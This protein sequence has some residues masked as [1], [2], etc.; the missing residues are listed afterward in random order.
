[1][2]LKMSLKLPV[3]EMLT[4][5]LESRQMLAI[6]LMDSGREM[7]ESV[8]KSDLTG[9]ILYLC[10]RLGWTETSESG[11]SSVA[12]QTVI[13]PNDVK[14]L[15]KLNELVENRFKKQDADMEDLKKQ[16]LYL[17]THPSS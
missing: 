2:A 13:V 11:L 10:Q 7:T 6:Y 4:A 3:I 9:I 15:E 5:E 14:V 17:T 1:M 12:P 16:V 8:T